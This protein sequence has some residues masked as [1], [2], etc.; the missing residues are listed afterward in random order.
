MK[1]IKT[2]ILTIYTVKGKITCARNNKTGRFVKLTI[3]AKEL[4]NIQAKKIEKGF[5]FAN[6]S[7]V[8]GFI[9]LFV[10]FF[11]AFMVKKD[12]Y[13][14]AEYAAIF[15]ISLAVLSVIVSVL[16]YIYNVISD[17]MLNNKYKGIIS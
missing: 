10:F 2:A 1:I 16:T 14:F 11:F 5:D 7:T 15:F 17:I 3:A 9:F 4:A 13:V 6:C 8:M 12:G